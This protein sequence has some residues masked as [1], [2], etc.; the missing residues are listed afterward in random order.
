[1][2]K[3]FII[4]L[5][6]LLVC[7]IFARTVTHAQKIVDADD[8]K[9][10]AF[11]N[12]SISLSAAYN[13]QNVF[14][15]RYRINRSNFEDRTTY[16][17][18]DSLDAKNS[19]D[20][21]MRIF[22]TL[23]SGYYPLY[24]LD[25]DLTKIV[26]YNEYEGIRLGLGLM[27]NEEISELFSAGGYF[28]Y[29]F[30]DKDWKYGGKLRFNIHEKSES[31]LILSYKDDV[32][33]TGGYEFLRE[34]GIF[35]PAMFRQYLVDRMD[36]VNEGQ[37]SYSLRTLKYLRLKFF[38]RHST[39]DPLADY[40]FGTAE[41]VYQGNFHITETG[42][43]ARFAWK[44]KFAETPWGKFP[45]GTD[46][47]VVYTNLTQGMNFLDGNFE[48][49]KMEAAVS[50]EIPN[51]NVGKTK[52]RL[53]GGMATGA[54]PAFNLYTGHG[55]YGSRFN[56]Y[57]ENSFTTMKL[58]EF[59]ADRFVSL[60]LSQDFHSLL[61]REEGFSPHIM[62]LNNLGWGWLTSP[63][64]HRGVN[65]QSFGKGYFETGLL[66]N[67]IL[68]TSL[69]SYGFGLFYRYG[70]YAFDKFSKNLAYRISVKFNL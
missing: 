30:H 14:R 68:G 11:S 38:I 24:F 1:M 47:P 13:P 39:V 41:K 10:L 25:I 55:S 63:S 65:T 49:I 52:I 7:L 35:S 15:E 44:E 50:D 32:Q 56:M 8:N 48:Y 40:R 62:W 42:F 51:R 31:R 16:Q 61:F 70:P 23:S 45:L 19:F 3:P 18:I 28:G 57:S 66:I 4:R 67:E 12:E 6:I 20:T 33:E 36:R 27:T 54:V 53:V 17:D 9:P 29:G 37:I 69:F 46:F 22:K 58:S 5:Y 26:S 60:Y 21:R 2:R 59:L 43:K 64:R 34:Q